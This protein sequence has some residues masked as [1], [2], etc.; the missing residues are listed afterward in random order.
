[1]RIDFIRPMMA[2]AAVALGLLQG[3]ANVNIQDYASERPALDLRTYFNGPI[4]AWGMFQ[5]R[6][7]KVVKRFKVNIDAKWDGDRLVV[8]THGEPGQPGHHHVN[9]RV[10]A[11]VE[12]AHAAAIRLG[13]VSLVLSQQ[14]SPPCTPPSALSRSA[15]FR[16]P[17]HSSA[18]RSPSTRLQLRH[19]YDPQVRTPSL[20]PASSARHGQRQPPVNRLRPPL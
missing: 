17:R 3:C 16:P 7:G 11:H 20:C 5:D 14:A 13:F 19:G 9:C 8:V 6:S 2:A 18:L 1:M 10:G 12:R 4:E 15:R